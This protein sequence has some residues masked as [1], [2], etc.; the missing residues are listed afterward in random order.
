MSA[1]GRIPRYASPALSVAGGLIL[2]LAIRDAIHH[3]RSWLLLLAVGAG[4]FLAGQL[5]LWVPYLIVRRRLL[6]R[7]DYL[8]RMRDEVPAMVAAALLAERSRDGKEA[9]GHGRPDPR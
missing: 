4:V 2:G 7:R 5:V 3:D 6:R 8:L 1:L 9:P